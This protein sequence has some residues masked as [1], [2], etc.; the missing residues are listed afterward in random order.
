MSVDDKV[1][2]S[3]SLAG[4]W[5]WDFTSGTVTWSDGL[6]RLLGL[7]PRAVPP[8]Y[9]LFVSRVHPEDRAS[10]EATSFMARSGQMLDAAFRIV[11]PDGA[12]RWAASVGEVFQDAAGQPA[13][14]AGV[15]IDVT[16]IRRAQLELAA[17]E[18]RYRALATANSLGQWRAS[19][20][21]EILECNFWCEITG[22]SPEEAQWLG[23][24]N[25]IHPDDVDT[26]SAIW[27][28]AL[29]L[30]SSTQLSYRV[31]HCSGEYRWILTK[32]VPIRNAD[33]SIREWVGSSE[34]IHAKR[35]AEEA[36][37]ANEE[38]MRLA[39]AA[40]RMI[41]WDY[42]LG[43]SCVTRSANSVDV[44]G[45]GSGPIEDLWARMHPDDRPVAMKALQAAK[46]SGEPLLVQCRL[47]R[48]DGG[49]QWV[50]AQAQ[51]LRNARQGS[52]RIVGVTVDIT[53]QKAAEARYEEERIAHEATRKALRELE[54]Q[55]LALT[56]AAGDIVWSS[57]PDGQ[58][59]DIPGWREF[60]GQTPEQVQNWG[61]LKAVHPAD[62]ER[63][64]DSMQRVI[65]ERSGTLFD[66]R[67]R[68]KDGAYQWFEVRIVPVLADDGTV[69]HWIGSCQ[70]IREALPVPTGTSMPTLDDVRR[71]L[72]QAQILPWQVRAAR[73]I[74][75][76]SARE[77]AEAAGVSLST[78]RRIEEAQSHDARMLA[79]VRSTLEQTG[80]E[81][82]SS[83]D[84][85]GSVRPAKPRQN[86]P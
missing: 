35:E 51:V 1:V 80:V 48:S 25:A 86:H 82:L 78:V 36:L 52:T 33:G 73:A 23:W 21:G 28:D 53:S 61:W 29:Q 47:Y 18:E 57:S 34:D 5:E 44:T 20:E 50:H 76:W 77:L 66:C 7:N 39:L 10:A 37:R 54:A 74:V 38:R 55:H 71:P 67:V 26:V 41:T 72:A 62:R 75:G 31:R 2:E 56:K 42:D 12:E 69:R 79:A 68:D 65:D 83:P 30:G 63:I 40:A 13:W 3:L 43:T 14:A 27:L 17:R 64:R 19:P 6:F 58:V 85:Q 8:S 9:D 45:L 49:I 22:Q 24:L 4:T 11:T 84:G 16:D 15:L 60:T 70:R 81:F 32:M 46:T 59:T